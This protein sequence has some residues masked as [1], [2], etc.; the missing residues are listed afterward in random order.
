MQYTYD[1]IIIGGGSAGLSLCSAAAQLGVKVCLIDKDKLGGDCLHYG[2]VPSKALIKSGKVAHHIRHADKYGIKAAEPKITWSDVTGR[3][4]KIQ[5]KIQKHD[6]P[7]RFRS[8]G[9]DVIFGRA[10][11]K[12]PHTIKIELNPKLSR[13]QQRKYKTQKTTTITGKKICIAT[14]SRPRIPEIKGLKE[15]GFITNE[16]I[17]SSKVQPKSLTIIGGGVIATELAQAMQ[18]LGTQVTILERHKT[19]LGHFDADTRDVMTKKLKSEGVQIYTDVEPLEVKTVKIGRQTK[20]CLTLKVKNKTIE[21]TTDEILL[22]AGRIPNTELNLEAAGVK[23]GPRGI[24]TKPNCRTNVPHI[25]AIGD[26][27]GHTPFTHAANYEAGIV[28][29]NEFLKVPSKA[30]YDSIG[31]TIYTDPEIAHIGHDEASADKAKLK[32]HVQKF[33]LSGNDRALTESGSEG[34]IKVLIGKKNKVLGVQIVAPRAG[35]MIREWQLAIAQGLD[36]SKIARS[37]YIY[38]TY[39]EASKWLAGQYLA[40]KLFNPKVRKIVR[41]LFGYRGKA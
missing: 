17:F 7:D 13:L 21:F 41:R 25:T 33:N 32:Y 1:L 38:P 31:W 15:A 12:D 8:Y 20:K 24:A 10:E 16:Q 19:Y 11:F 3:I 23:Y 26:I 30:S 6:D 29:T 14:G 9:A 4:A 35:E 18:R 28:F 40:P 2:C 22:A 37:T 5:S 34:F 36:I 27:N 39:G